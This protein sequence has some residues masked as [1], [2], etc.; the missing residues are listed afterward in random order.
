SQD[1]QFS[2]SNRMMCDAILEGYRECLERGGRPIVLAERHT[3]LRD[4]AP[5]NPPHPVVF[6][7]KLLKLPIARD[8]VPRAL[9]L[10]ALPKGA[11]NLRISRRV[12][13]V[14]SLGRPRFVALPD[15]DG[16]LV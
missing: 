7:E 1:G 6:W 4:I 15:S 16:G 3:W 14:G 10:A 9:L 12:A 13:G 11:A 2:L 5:G 8:G